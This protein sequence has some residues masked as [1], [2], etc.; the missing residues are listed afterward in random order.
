MS[1]PHAQNIPR[2]KMKTPTDTLTQI[3]AMEQAARA[4]VAMLMLV[5]EGIESNFWSAWKFWR[6]TIPAATRQHGTQ[7]LRWHIVMKV[8]NSISGASTGLL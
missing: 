7:E 4:Q 1:A 3:L 6:E 5:L 8:T 2:P